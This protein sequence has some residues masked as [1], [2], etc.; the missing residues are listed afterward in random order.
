MKRKRDV[1]GIEIMK[2][3]EEK[4]YERCMKAIKIP[5]FAELDNDLMNNLNFFAKALAFYLIAVKVCHIKWNE[6]NGI[7]EEDKFY[8]HG[9]MKKRNN[10]KKEENIEMWSIGRKMISIIKSIHLTELIMIVIG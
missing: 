8:S 6:R 9:R 1:F 4:A 2:L 3:T 5:L 7:T 10:V